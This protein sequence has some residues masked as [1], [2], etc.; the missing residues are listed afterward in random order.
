MWGWANRR[1]NTTM[2]QPSEEHN[3]LIL[4]GCLMFSQ[5][6]R[7]MTQMAAW[8]PRDFFW[9][10][11]P[12]ATLRWNERLAKWGLISSKLIAG[13]HGLLLGLLQDP[14]FW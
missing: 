4:M 2:G 3:H 7:L 1:N 9:R 14:A 12:I 10:D 8:Q 6:F 11:G 5:G 13:I